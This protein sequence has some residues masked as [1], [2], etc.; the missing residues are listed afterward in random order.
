[1]ASCPHCGRPFQSGTLRAKAVA[2]EKAFDRKANALFLAALVF[3]PA[4]LLLVHF[5]GY[6]PGTP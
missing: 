1:V 4:V 2:E 3:V 5:Q 6:L